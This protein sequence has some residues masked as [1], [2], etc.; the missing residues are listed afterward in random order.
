M[1]LDAGTRLGVYEIVALIGAGGM[2]EVYRAHDT[3]LGRDVAIKILPDA[4]ANDP[5]R[6]ARFTREA[7]T[8]AALNH[9][10]IAHVYGFEPLAPVHALVMELVEGPTLADRI[11]QGPVPVDESIRIARQIAE[12]LETAHEH[13]IIHRDLKPANVKIRDDGAVKV[14][15]FGLAKAADAAQASAGISQSPTITTPAMSQA[16]VILGTAA[17]MSPEQAKGRPADKRGDVWA[18]GCLLYEMLTGRRAFEGEDVSDTLA[19]IL[20]GEPDWTAFP[21]DIPAHLRTIV[22]RCLEKNRKARIPDMAVVRFMLDEST[23]EAARVGE[24]EIRDRWRERRG[25][26]AAAVLAVAFLTASGLAGFMYFTKTPGDARTIRFTLELPDGWSLAVLGTATTSP[27]NPPMSVSPDGRQV[28]FVAFSKGIQRLWVR[29]LDS[30][31]ARQLPGTDGAVGPFWSPDSRFVAFFADDKL[32]KIDVASGRPVTLCDAP[33]QLG[34]AWSPEGFILFGSSDRAIQRVAAAGG[35]PQVVT[36]LAQGE[37]GHPA[38][39]PDGR[40]FFYRVL[41][42]SYPPGGPVYVGSV[43]STERAMVLERPDASNVMYAAG[44][45]VFLR[46]TTLMAQPFDLERMALTGEPTPM[47]EEIRT[48]GIPALAVFSVSPTGVLAYATGLGGLDRQLTWFDRDGKVL[49]TLGDPA[50]YGDVELS[51]DGTRVAVSIFDR[52]KQTRDIWTIDVARALRTR[53]TSEPSNETTAIW[54]PDG[55]RIVFN[56]QRK[57]ALDLYEKASD[58]SGPEKLLLS[59]DRN[60]RPLRWPRDG[61]FLPYVSFRERLQESDVW[62]LPLSG[63]RKPV[64][65]LKTPFT[66]SDGQ[67][68]PDGRWMA[69]TSNDS[70]SDEIYVVPFPGPGGKARVSTGGGSW[71]RWRDDGREIFYVDPDSQLMAA[72]VTASGGTF[73]VVEVRPL[74]QLRTVLRERYPYDVSKDGQRFLV[75]TTDRTGITSVTVVVNGPAAVRH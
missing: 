48:M 23:A 30:L 28:A 4:F 71:P 17:Y 51:P 2:G 38:F 68:S 60:K 26:I 24:R 63:D 49:G 73:H 5:E 59:D 62:L 16:G 35:V 15:D 20:R 75:N 32:K 6:L 9:V 44:N 1:S 10:N 22:R 29:P 39:L 46:E 52:A 65:F 70:S 37:R 58:L 40:H 34:G 55:T 57:A 64:P 42:T 45:L 47:A 53:F 43:G 3:S 7:K 13:G 61:R 41:L 11:A 31:E 14:L 36:T 12:A 69:Y 56:S 50:P 74:F 25:W 19:A 21:P 27:G 72:S 18:F 8:L 54:S 33:R 67:L 66:E